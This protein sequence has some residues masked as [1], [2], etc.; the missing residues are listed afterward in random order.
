MLCIFVFIQQT[1]FWG[2]IILP[3]GCHDITPAWVVMLPD[4]VIMPTDNKNRT[5][6]WVERFPGW[7]AMPLDRVV[8]LPDGKIELRMG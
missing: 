5:P 2:S 1:V 8:T 4:R 3:S 6:D 7:F